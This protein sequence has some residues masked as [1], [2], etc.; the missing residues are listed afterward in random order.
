M[1]NFGL[2]LAEEFSRVSLLLR[3]VQVFAGMVA[4]TVWAF[5]P[6]VGWL[7]CCCC[8]FRSGGNL[9]SSFSM[10][11]FWDFGFFRL[12]FPVLVSG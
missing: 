9:S 3:F 1:P 12:L 6:A 4:G 10:S 8:L 7:C 5:C 11:A 2:L